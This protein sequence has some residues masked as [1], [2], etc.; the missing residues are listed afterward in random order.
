M[1]AAARGPWQARVLACKTDRE[2][3][4]P[5]A[6]PF[7]SLIHVSNPDSFI[8]EVTEEVRRDRLFA[9]FRKYGW[10]G[11]LV[12]LGVVGGTAYNEWSK[13]RE[14]ARA[15]SFGDSLM[16]ALDLGTPTDR[17]D[18]L[19]AIPAD[20]AQDAIL[21]LILA[22][23]PS[24]NRAQTLD[25]LAALEADSTQPQNYRDLAT[26]RRVIVAGKD[27]SVADRRT[28]LDPIAAPGRPFRPL[29]LEQLAYLLVEEGKTDE[30]ITAL[31]AL[32]T[33]Q[34]APAGLRRR[35]QQV[36]VALGGKVEAKVDA[37]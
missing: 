13:A 14:E 32:T 2:D 29:A 4:C 31:T 8:D 18:A 23:D 5:A 9:T 7:E 19:K 22:S 33:E 15:Q 20:K 11:A 24:E 12:V 30:A 21:Q 6:S 16:D 25:A 36:I 28:A 34:E 35:A 3:R 27:L 37:G 26:L 10:I 1:R 17:R